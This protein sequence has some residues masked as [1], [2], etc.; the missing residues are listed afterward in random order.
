MIMSRS[1]A[2][3]ARTRVFSIG[4]DARP[5]AVN[6]NYDG[7][8]VLHR[9]P[10]SFSHVTLSRRYRV[11]RGRFAAFARP[12]LTKLQ[13]RANGSRGVQSTLS[14]S[15]SPSLPFSL[16][17]SFSRVP[18]GVFNSLGGFRFPPSRD[19][20][21]A[22]LRKCALRLALPRSL[23]PCFPPLFPYVAP[24]PT[25]IRIYPASY[26]LLVPPIPS[27][28]PIYSSPPLNEKCF[29]FL[30]SPARLPGLYSSR[31]SQ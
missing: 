21:S 22:T 29:A 11:F 19:Q 23:S 12:P 28:F 15:L 26:G 6:N 13:R 14:F 8:F 3:P 24:N 5:S 31:Q 7:R 25:F 30:V 10:L 16:F 17:L 1:C 2:Q 9:P 20:Y 18:V 4:A 27:L